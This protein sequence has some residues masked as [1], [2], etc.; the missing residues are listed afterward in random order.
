[1]WDEN[2][3][4][5]AT[6]SRQLALRRH[7]DALLL[8]PDGEDTGEGRMRAVDPAATPAKDAAMMGGIVRVREGNYW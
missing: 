7:G 8:D 1:V 4:N 3:A 6:V 5:A 2:Y